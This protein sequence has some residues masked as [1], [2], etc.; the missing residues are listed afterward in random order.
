MRARAGRS[1]DELAAEIDG[2]ADALWLLDEA[3]DDVASDR[4]ALART[5][6]VLDPSD[7][8]PLEALRQIERR[9]AAGRARLRASR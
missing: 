7:A 3:L 2:G 1:R 9:V 5:F 8:S 6:F 4:D